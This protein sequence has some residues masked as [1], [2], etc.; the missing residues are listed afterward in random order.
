MAQFIVRV[1]FRQSKSKSLYEQV[2]IKLKNEGFQ[3]TTLING[4]SV[5][6]PIGEF[7]IN[8]ERHISEI[9]DLV[10]S[11]LSGINDEYSI[12]ISEAV[13]LDGYNLS[14]SYTQKLK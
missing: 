4:I 5:Q 9:I 13:N 6:L 11:I 1:E 7:C 12:L 3:S 8:R 10:K 14:D 2:R